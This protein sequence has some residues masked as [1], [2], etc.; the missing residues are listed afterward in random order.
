MRNTAGKN[1]G[2]LNMQ[3]SFS[4]KKKKKVKL[5][6]MKKKTFCLCM[7]TNNGSLKFYEKKEE[8]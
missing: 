5:Q 2:K 1:S 8:T 3:I 7:V 4:V 6:W